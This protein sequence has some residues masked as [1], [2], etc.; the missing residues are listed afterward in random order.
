MTAS[1]YRHRHC[2][3]RLADM[4]GPT[5]E[6]QQ[7]IPQAWREPLR[8]VVRA[9]AEGDYGLS[10]GVAGV[11]P[12]PAS[13]AKQFGEYVV[14]YGETLVE[15]PE[16]T[17]ATSVMQWIGPHWEFWVDLWTAEEGRSDMVLAGHVVETADTYRFTLHLV[18]VP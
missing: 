12:V 6:G 11:D 1:H 4:Q 14:D 7:P 10:R 17:W 18:Y 13:K 3:G 8:E 2:P 9:F 15:L 5:K 16:E